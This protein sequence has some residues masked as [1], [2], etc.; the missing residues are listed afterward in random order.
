LLFCFS[1]A[2]AIAFDRRD[3]GMMN[4]PVDEGDDAGGAWENTGPIG[5]GKMVVT[6]ID[7][8]VAF[9]D[10]L[11]EEVSGGL[12]VGEIAELIDAEELGLV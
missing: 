6:I 5:E 1:S 3:F 9:R 8:F 12:V 11:E 4:E 2:I 10:D 7:F